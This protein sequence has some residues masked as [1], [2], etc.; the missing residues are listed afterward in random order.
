MKLELH[1]RAPLLVRHLKQVDPSHGAGDVQQRV[2]PAEL[3]QRPSNNGFGRRWGH[4]IQIK[5][6]RLGAVRPD[7]F[8]SRLQIPPF[9]AQRGPTTRNLEK[10]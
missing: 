8:G 4:K 3:G 1:A 5:H 10:A 6:E 2:D 9:R 7:T